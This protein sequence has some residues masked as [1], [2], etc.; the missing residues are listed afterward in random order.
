M[1]DY[2]PYLSILRNRKLSQWKV[3]KSIVSSLN[4]KAHNGKSVGEEIF[5]LKIVLDEQW[6]KWFIIATNKSRTNQS[7]KLRLQKLWE[8]IQIKFRDVKQSQPFTRRGFWKNNW[9]KIMLQVLNL[10]FFIYGDSLR[11]N[12]EREGAVQTIFEAT[13][14]NLAMA[15]W[16]TGLFYIA[17]SFL[18]KLNPIFILAPIISLILQ[19]YFSYRRTMQFY[20]LNE[21]NK[22]IRQ[23]KA[24]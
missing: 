6:H 24:S 5:A 11:T 12:F 7:T 20:Y 10:D 16:S 14:R 9:G 23:A 2:F 17:P 8:T 18:V 3:L 1:S 21:I 22:K 13:R 4:E 19:F 15:I